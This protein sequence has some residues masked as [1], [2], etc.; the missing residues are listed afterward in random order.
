MGEAEQAMHSPIQP[1]DAGP[2]PLVN[3]VQD[4]LIHHKGNTC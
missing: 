4:V 1:S 2:L 3:T